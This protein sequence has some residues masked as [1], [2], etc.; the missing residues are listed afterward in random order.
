MEFAMKHL[1]LAGVALALLTVPALAQGGGDILSGAKAFGGWQADAPGVRRH[2][3]ESD[4]PAPTPPEAAT[5]GGSEIVARPSDALPKV[6]TGF[7][8]D[9]VVDGIK[10][11]RAIRF[12]PN[13]DLFVSDS[14][15]G[16]VLVY[17][18]ANGAAK[19]ASSETF[20]KGLTQP[21]GIAFYPADKPQWVYI[22][23][24]DGLKRFAYKDGDMQASG[25]PE[26]ILSGVPASHHWTRDV[27]FS[28][29]GKTMYYSVGSGSNVGLDMTMKE[30]P[31][32]S[33]EK[34]AADHPLGVAWGEEEGRAAVLAFD[35]D[36]QNGRYVA[37]G[38]RN[39]AGMTLQ[40][41]TGDVWCAVNERDDLGDNTPFDY[42]TSVRQGAFYGWPWFYN[43]DHP[44]PRWQATPRNDIKDKVMVADVLFQAHSAPLNIVFD[45]SDAWGADFKGAAFVAMHGSWNRGTPTGYKVVKLDIGPDGKAN[46]IYEDFVTGF[47]LPDGQVWGRPVGVAFDPS[48]NLFVSDDGSG[49]IW[50]VSRAD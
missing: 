33:V 49:S 15:S 47:V 31:P 42:A 10:N 2:I 48:G 20:A 24:F 14:E 7:R 18:F 50:K 44:D 41:A 13:G 4:L 30:Q 25:P 12:A 21:Y 37:T 26:T 19:P 27:V 1:S 35:P 36:G 40:P 5:S 3:T 45:T 6:P 32:E 23:E 29:D 28:P 43:G 11:P 9:L 16:N 38:I 17:R 46:G 39:C 34:F 22:A 8:V